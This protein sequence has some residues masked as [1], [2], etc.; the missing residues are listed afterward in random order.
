MNS[1][2]CKAELENYFT[3]YHCRVIE[4]MDNTVKIIAPFPR[5]GIY[6]HKSYKTGSSS[7]NPFV[8]TG[9][10]TMILPDKNMPPNKLTLELSLF[11]I[12]LWELLFSIFM[13]AAY[14]LCFTINHTS[15]Q[16]VFF[17]IASILLPFTPLVMFW[18]AIS[19]TKLFF[20]KK[21]ENG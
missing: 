6:D 2:Y 18:K 4:G 9:S 15:Y 3:K 20:K 10:F 8:F 16:Y 19:I 11:R 17:M 1:N 5:F 7:F 21:R 12:I 14:V 13:Y